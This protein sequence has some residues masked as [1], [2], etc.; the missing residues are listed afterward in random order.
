MHA[1]T[2]YAALVK[3][4]ILRIIVDT[5]TDC[6]GMNC[7]LVISLLVFLLMVQLDTNRMIIEGKIRA[8]NKCLIG[9]RE[10]RD[11]KLTLE[12]F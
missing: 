6:R 7:C 8:I 2:F 3:G 11:D 12:T 5:W 10:F 1:R 4:D 9:S